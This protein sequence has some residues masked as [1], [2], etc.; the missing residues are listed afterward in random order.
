MGGQC[1]GGGGGEGWGGD[2]SE[3]PEGGRWTPLPSGYLE[4]QMYVCVR[5]VGE[6]VEVVAVVMLMV[7]ILKASS[8]VFVSLLW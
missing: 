2:C 6:G 5:G 7:F 3:F 8:C 4:A 1:G